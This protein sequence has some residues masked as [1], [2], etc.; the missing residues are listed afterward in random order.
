MQRHRQENPLTQ[1]GQQHN[2]LPPNYSPAHHLSPDIPNNSTTAATEAKTVEDST[3][4]ASGWQGNGN[5]NRHPGGQNFNSQ[6]AQAQR[7]NHSTNPFNQALPAMGQEFEPQQ[8]RPVAA[9]FAAAEEG[10]TGIGVTSTVMAT[11]LNTKVFARKRRSGTNSN[12]TAT[13]ATRAEYQP[14][15]PTCL[16]LKNNSHK[17]QTILNWQVTPGFR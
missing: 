12:H 7:Q 10:A 14:T 9:N 3:I 5:Y 2:N 8:Q 6:A 11:E 1:A 16:T 4:G 13:G 15:P 17:T